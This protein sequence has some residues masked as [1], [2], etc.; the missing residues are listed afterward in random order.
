MNIHIIYYNIHK[1]IRGRCVMFINGVY[2]SQLLV[3]YYFQNNN[4]V[5]FY[6]ILGLYI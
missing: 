4:C 1:L 5:I 6:K 3:D 2:V